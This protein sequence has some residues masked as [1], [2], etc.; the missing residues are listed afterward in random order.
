MPTKQPGFPME[1]FKARFFFF[2]GSAAVGFDVDEWIEKC[3][4]GDLAD[5]ILVN[6]YITGWLIGVR[7]MAYYSPYI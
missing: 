4:A 6:A 5:W 7:I 3:S 1:R 2:G